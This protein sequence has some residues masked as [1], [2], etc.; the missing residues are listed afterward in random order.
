[1]ERRLC[2]HF[3]RPASSGESARWGSRAINAEVP[4]RNWPTQP[5]RAKG[6]DPQRVPPGRYPITQRRM[7][8]AVG[9]AVALTLEPTDLGRR[10]K[11]SASA[12]SAVTGSGDAPFDG[13]ENGAGA[14]SRFGRRF[15]RH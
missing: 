1:M 5:G 9:A 14:S 4:D 11:A 10:V 6:A 15:G 12:D 2:G 7:T 3:D 8:W 13:E